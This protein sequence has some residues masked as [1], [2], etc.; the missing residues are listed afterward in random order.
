MQFRVLKYSALSHL[1]VTRS[2]LLVSS[3]NMKYQYE[4]V[5]YLVLLNHFLFDLVICL[6]LCVTGARKLLGYLP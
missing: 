2:L 5:P 6:C 3:Y 1:F 4:I